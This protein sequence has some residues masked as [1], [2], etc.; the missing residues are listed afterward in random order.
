MKRFCPPWIAAA[1]LAASVGLSA[2]ASGPAPTRLSYLD[3]GPIG[4][5]A[6]GAAAPTS[7]PDG[8][9]LGVPLKVSVAA[10]RWLD[11]E[12][13]YYRL[14][15]ADGNQARTYANSRW[16]A[17]PPVMFANHLRARLAR[18]GQV[19]DA[20]DPARAP[21]LKIDL[22]EFTQYFDGPGASHG[23]VLLRASVFDNGKL[24]AQTTIRDEHPAASA[25]AQGGA[26]ALAAATA[27]AGDALARWLTTLP[28]VPHAAHSARAF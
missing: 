19:L 15:S 2:C 11:S 24:I 9:R 10:P 4:G 18:Q 20:G 23:V 28:L 17:P 3:L 22:D 5:P 26:T 14:P 12:S 8:M 7:A 27:A 6:S 16:L 21:L 1:A 25:D 13:I